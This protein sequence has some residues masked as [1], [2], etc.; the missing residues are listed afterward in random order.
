MYGR[1]QDPEDLLVK[2]D[3]SICQWRGKTIAM[4]VSQQKTATRPD[5][6]GIVDYLVEHVN[7]YQ[8][9]VVVN[10]YVALKTKP[11]VILAGPPD[12]DKMCLAQGLAEILVGWP[13]LQWCL[14]QAHPWWTTRTGAPSHFAMA[15]AQFNTVKLLDSIEA[16]LAGEAI[17]L[18][19]FIGI[20]RMSPAE[21]VCYFD[22][23]PRG[24]LWQADGSTVRIPR[25]KNLYITGTLDVEG[26]ARAVLSQE[27]YRHA[28]VIQ[29][30]R[31]HFA[32]SARRR[33]TSQQRLDWQQRFARST[34]RHGDHARAKLAQIL[35][36]GHAPFAPLDE[37][38]RRLGAA[39]FSP[40]VFEEAWLYLANAF[41]GEGHGLFVEPVI[42]NLRIA[43]DYVLMQSVLP[44]V[45]GQW[46]GASGIWSEVSEY[47]APRFPRAYAWVVTSR[48]PETAESRRKV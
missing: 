48:S 38:E 20:E 8:R 19:F 35:P 13:S 42:E 15:H 21:V 44:R 41:D 3:V 16:A 24:L 1:V 34:I 9:E 5:E 40:F 12:V 26:Q 14:F 10:Y 7:A 32:P 17:G 37:L 39:G 45:S 43:Q 28:T 27:V 36:N 11:F 4:Q 18:P 2:E 23:L 47:L 25:S 22:D 33:K 30:D 6:R 29:V 46:A 31:G